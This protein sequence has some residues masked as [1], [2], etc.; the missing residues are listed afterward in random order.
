GAGGDS[1]ADGASGAEDRQAQFRTVILLRSP[2]GEELIAEGIV[3]G[4]IAPEER[5]TR[6]F[7]YDSLF[8]PTEG[9]GRTF[10][11]MSAAEKNEL[12]H[13]GRAARHLAQLLAERGEHG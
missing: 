7:G 3:P 12:S 6:G 10:A 2:E 4:T 8:V 1:G 11:E 13:R 9:D 5:G